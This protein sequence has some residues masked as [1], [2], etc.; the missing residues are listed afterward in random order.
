MLQKQQVE[1]EFQICSCIL[2]KM[3]YALEYFRKKNKLKEGKL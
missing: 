3:L 1:L 2:G